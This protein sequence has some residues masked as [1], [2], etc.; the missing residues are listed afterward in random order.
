[1]PR[2]SPSALAHGLAER[3]AD[4]LDGVM[5]VH[6]EIACGRNRQVESAV[7]R[8]ELEHVVEEADAGARRRI[9]RGRRGRSPAGSAFRWFVDQR[10][11]DARMSSRAASASVVCSTTPAVRRMQPAQPGADDLSRTRMPS[12]LERLGDGAGGRADA[13]QHEV[14]LA[15]PERQPVAPA[16][17]VDQLRATCATRPRTTRGTPRSSSAASSAAIAQ[18]L[19]LNG[20]VHGPQPA[21][22]GSGARRARRPAAPPGRGP[23]R[24][25]GRSRGCAGDRAAAR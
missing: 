5:R 15:R 20:G 3:D 14:R 16:E 6:V 1:M 18:M 25:C 21:E 9:G 23:S 13:K 19:T 11:R 7:T 2:L 12:G 24:T 10:A 4:V 22:R 8:E 17:V